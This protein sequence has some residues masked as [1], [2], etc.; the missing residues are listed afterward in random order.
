MSVRVL[1]LLALLPAVA[2]PQTSGGAIDLTAPG[3]LVAVNTTVTPVTFKGR[4]AVRV[5][6]TQPGADPAP[7]TLA[8]VAGSRFR[9]GAIELALAGEPGPGAP[10]S[11]RGFI[12]L[13]FRIQPD[14]ARYEYLY[15]RMTN[16]RADDQVRRNHSVQYASHP[17]WHWPRM[18]KEFPEKYESYVDL[19]PSVWTKVRVEVDGAR[20]RLFVHGAEQPT[21][22]VNDLK[23]AE[24]D[25]GIALWIDNHT[26]GHFA[27]LIVTPR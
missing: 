4:R 23:Q 16:G 17:E 25:G 7:G 8:L 18:R 1:A 20:A 3:A 11:A 5:V 19:Q 22:V 24:A 10:E 6:E 27:D 2:V 13:A 21:L 12:G 14:A 26:V 15:L 9:N